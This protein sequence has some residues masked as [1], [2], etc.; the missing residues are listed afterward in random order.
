MTQWL[1]KQ[2]QG[3]TLW[4]I[5]LLPI[6]LIYWGLISVR[7]LLYRV[8]VFKS[9][10]LRA[11]VIIV[12]NINVGGTGKTPLVVWLV[13]RLKQAG[14]QP[15]VVSR[16]YGGKIKHVVEVTQASNPQ[17]VGD[18]PV[19]IATQ[20]GCPVFVGV[21]R[22]E[23]GQALLRAYP[24]CDVVISDDGLQHYSLQRDIELIV[25]DGKLVFGNGCLLPAGPLREPVSRMRTVDAVISNGELI[26]KRC[27]FKQCSPVVM[28]LQPAPFYN[29]ANNQQKVDIEAFEGKRVLA[30]AGIGNPARFFDQLTRLGLKFE[31]RAFEDHHQFTP[32]D[33]DVAGTDVI[34]MTEKD[35]VK[36]SAFA[37]DNIWVLPVRVVVSE[38]LITGI[39]KK[40]TKLRM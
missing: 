6:S 29:L 26:G 30:V 3:F 22:V 2:W 23:A 8:G 19:L 34:V 32:A 35:A 37:T 10:R 33:L 18:E 36:C 24:Q 7:R 5:L 13:E 31:A 40:L 28:Q 17:L 9:D 14:Y 25:L 4:H 38:D 12:G 39:L 27:L 20:A 15:G 16:G 21:K 11:P 1:K